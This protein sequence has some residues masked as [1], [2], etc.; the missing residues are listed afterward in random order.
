[1]KI[2]DLFTKPTINLT[3]YQSVD[4]SKFLHAAEAQGNHRWTFVGPG[5]NEWQSVQ[6][7]MFNEAARNAAARYCCD[8]GTKYARL[9]LTSM[10]SA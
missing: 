5:G 1:M 3:S 4:V 10:E 8:Y 6:V 7:G 9:I 2:K